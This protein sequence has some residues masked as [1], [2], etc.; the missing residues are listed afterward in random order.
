[1]AR[2]ETYTDLEG[3]ELSLARLDEN[4]L[5]LVQTL[6]GRAT[7]HPDWNDFDNF[8][9]KAVG[10][11]YDARRV[12]RKKSAKTVVFQIAQDL[13]DRIGIAAGLVRLPDYRDQLA[14]LIRTR[15]KNRRAF[16]KKT[17]LSETM[18]SHVLSG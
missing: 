13:S 4:E 15:F 5:K 2:N 10:E 16:C 1:M 12:P 8:W 3:R 14:D 9:M 11:F 7:A 18:L 6:R 17:R